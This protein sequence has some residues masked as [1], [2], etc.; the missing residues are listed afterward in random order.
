MSDPTTTFQDKST[1]VTDDLAAYEA[2][3][4]QS[5]AG[6]GG[7]GTLYDTYG[8]KITNVQNAEGSLGS[9]NTFLVGLGDHNA[10]AA[11]Y[12]S[13]LQ[14]RTL[15]ILDTQISNT[16]YN[17][18]LLKNDDTNKARMADI[19]INVSKEYDAQ[20]QVFK[21]ISFYLVII[22]FFGVLGKFVPSIANIAKL[23]C[24]FVTL[25]M[26]YH[27][28]GK[29]VDM[30][31]R[32]STNYDEYNFPKPKSGDSTSTDTEDKTNSHAGKYCPPSFGSKDKEGFTGAIQ[33]YENSSNS[34][35]NKSNF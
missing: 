26:V 25:V 16:Q 2:D 29:M 32:S 8:A 18:G 21:M 34:L 22:L 27:L 3:L 23:M 12:N 17:I 4:T 5:Q 19:N 31:A 35:L 33:A 28:Y 10:D 15:D 30:Y 6:T 24:V 7:S 1:A 11:Q 20:M 13:H 14:D 9:L